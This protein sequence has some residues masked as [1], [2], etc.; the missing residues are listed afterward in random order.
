MTTK[1]RRRAP[2]RLNALSV[3]QLVRYLQD[4]PSNVPDL[5]E[6]SGLS[7]PTAR[8]FVL[9]MERA[10]A[11]RIVEWEPDRLGRYCTKV[12]AF[13][14]GKPAA[15]PKRRS[16]QPGYHSGAERQL[17]AQRRIQNALAGVQA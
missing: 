16:E 6:A 4:V 3:A 12:Y 11:I 1:R 9:A 14:G 10:G 5:A 17:R 2:S 8:R 15:K 13:G 7:V